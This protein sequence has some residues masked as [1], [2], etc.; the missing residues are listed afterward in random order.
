MQTKFMKLKGIIKTLEKIRMTIKRSF[1]LDGLE[2]EIA[3]ALLGIGGIVALVLGQKEIALFCFGAIA[4]YLSKGFREAN[5]E[6][7]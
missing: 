2:E 3:I 4:G 5:K 1:K 7:E 6:N